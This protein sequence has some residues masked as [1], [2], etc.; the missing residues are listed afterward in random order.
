ML[1]TQVAAGMLLRLRPDVYLAA[2]QWPDEARDQQV[3][4]ARA[5]Q[6]LHPA[7]VIS[8][9]S[10]ASL[11]GFPHPGFGDWPSEGVHLPRVAGARRSRNGVTHHLGSLPVSQVVRDAEGCRVTTAARTAVDLAD[12]QALPEALVLL[13]WAARLACEGF[14]AQARRRDYRNPQHVAAARE[15]LSDAALTIRSRRLQPAIALVEPSRESAIESLSAG[16]FELA[17]LPRPLC[18]EPIRTSFGTFYP[19][20][21][22][23]EQ[24]LIGEADGAGKY[25]GSDAV[26]HEREREELLRRL[27]YRV[28]RWLGK[29]I[30]AHPALV[31]ERVARELGLY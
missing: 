17:G 24:R 7:A 8:H 19:D 23:P 13:D 16:H 6:V 12:G 21:L 11:W 31:V 26:V 14:V 22:W 4:L 18:Q 10:A 30:M 20:F 2:A 29:E 1:R 3:V 9:A 27:D 5:E 25:E 28:V 15:L